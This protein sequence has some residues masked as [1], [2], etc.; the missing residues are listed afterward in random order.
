MSTM[1]F[2][3]AFALLD[4]DAPRTVPAK[5]E[6]VRLACLAWSLHPH[7]NPPCLTPSQQ[8]KAA[9]PAPKVE[10]APVKQ[11]RAPRGDRG[12]GCVTRESME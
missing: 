7:S 10:A 4:E 3:N 12:E 1:T 8:P 2:S 5:K 11:E 9:A 6:K